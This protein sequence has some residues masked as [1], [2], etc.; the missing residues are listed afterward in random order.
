MIRLVGTPGE[1]LRRLG[2]QGI[3]TLPPEQGGASQLLCDVDEC[4]CPRGRGYFEPISRDEMGALVDWMPTEEHW[5]IS[6]A[7]HGPKVKGNI[8]LAH[9][10]CNRLAG[11]DEERRRARAKKEE[12]AATHADEWRSE[13]GNREAAEAQWRQ[14]SSRKQA[15]PSAGHL[16]EGGDA[17]TPIA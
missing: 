16:P 4:Y 12:W 13:F 9:R 1:V 5:P 17:R 3:L 2:M 10:L 7:E 15:Y 11:L 6:H 8:W 14:H